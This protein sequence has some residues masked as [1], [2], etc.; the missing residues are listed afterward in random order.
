MTLLLFLLLQSAN[1]S[2]PAQPDT[3]AQAESPPAVA[4]S[5]ICNLKSEVA[6]GDSLLKHGFYTE[7]AQQYRRSLWLTDSFDDSAGLPYLKLGLSLAG[8]N[9]LF[10]ASEELRAAG[11]LQ[12]GLSAPAQT[13]LAGYYA[14]NRRYD[15]ASFEVS[16]LLVFTRDS[17]RR[18]SLNS[19]MGWLRLQDGDVASAAASYELAGRPDVASAL[20]LAKAVPQRSSTLAAVLSSVIPGLGEVYAGRPAPGLL[21]FAVSAGSLAW[22]VTA[23]RSDDWVSASVIVS[24]LF[25]R[26]YNGSR[27]NAVAFA[28]EYNMAARRHRIANLAPRIAEPDWFAGTDSLLGYKVRPDTAATD[29]VASLR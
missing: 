18:A 16:D 10:L 3:A 20:R 7:A 6:L 15:L 28:D 1:P 21:A 25:W 29:S 22:A 8:A 23:A 4:Q 26:F 27:A 12:P 24:V 14:H 9:Q 17:A 19:A 2:L 11:R 13:A 5:A